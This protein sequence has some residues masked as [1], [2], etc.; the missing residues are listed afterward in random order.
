MKPTSLLLKRELNPVTGK[1]IKGRHAH[2]PI[3]MET[4]AVI[5]DLPK[6]RKVL[7]Q[8]SLEIWFSE[9]GKKKISN[10]K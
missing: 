8:A 6:R 9:T 2:R 1:Q 4:G 3:D 5:T 7:T 10:Q